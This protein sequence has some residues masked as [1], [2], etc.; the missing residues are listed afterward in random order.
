M[1]DEKDDRDWLKKLHD[2]SAECLAVAGAMSAMSADVSALF[3]SDSPL[4]MRLDRLADRLYKAGE[5][6]QNGARESVS[7]ALKQSQETSGLLLNAALAGAFTARD[8]KCPVVFAE[9]EGKS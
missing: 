4:A 6:V 8:E 3:G 7:E 5:D 9:P 1:S 2:A